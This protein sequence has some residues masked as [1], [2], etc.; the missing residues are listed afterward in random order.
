MRPLRDP[1]RGTAAERAKE[2]L[3]YQHTLTPRRE[4]PSEAWKDRLLVM[5]R[6]SEP[7]KLGYP[8]SSGQFAFA[9]N[10][11]RTQGRRCDA[12]DRPEPQIRYLHHLEGPHRGEWIEKW[13]QSN[14]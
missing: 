10:E 11:E 7:R 1:D 9:M 2:S 3:H 8:G 5:F 13:N 12:L 4:P 6:V 14:Q